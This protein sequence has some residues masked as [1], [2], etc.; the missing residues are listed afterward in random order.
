MGGSRGGDRGPDRPTLENHRNIGFLSH[1]GLDPEKSQSYQA[2]IQSWAI[3]GT[4]A[5]RHLNGVSL[6][7]QCW[8]TFSGIWTPSSTNKSWTP[9]E[10]TFWIRACTSN[11]FLSEFPP[12]T[13][14]MP[15]QREIDHHKKLSKNL[16]EV[17]EDIGVSVD[18]RKTFIETATLTE[19]IGT[20]HRMGRQDI[21][22]YVFGS[23]YEGSTT[24]D[25]EADF[26]T[27]FVYWLIPVVNTVS[28]CSNVHGHDTYENYLI[29]PDKYAGYVKLQLLIGGIR[30]FGNKGISIETG[31]PTFKIETDSNNR[32]CVVG[33]QKLA[34]RFQR[35]G[36]VLN[37]PGG[38]YT[39]PADNCYC[40]NCKVWPECAAEWLTRKRNYGW[41]SAK[42]I[43]MCK[44]LGFLVVPKDH[45][46]SDEPE[47]M[48]R[49]SFSR[50]ERLFVSTFNSVQMKCY[51]LLKLI[52]KEVIKPNIKE[53]TL[54]SYHCKTCMF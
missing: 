38:I 40:L 26:D 8:S 14:A 25:M 52:N 32:F 7:G 5:K 2:R 6:V 50:Q 48:W 18:A 16:Y 51:I 44:S 10:K 20:I 19:I 36:P 28:E 17:L 41:P 42:Q 29:I 30:Q 35:K 47:K 49:I 1:T 9:S 24:F 21:I 45:P 13:K 12:G 27:A 37:Y 15:S 34:N 43:R 33:K 53:K 4:P 23:H 39:L 11:K 54:T 22:N 3:I 31:H 46:K